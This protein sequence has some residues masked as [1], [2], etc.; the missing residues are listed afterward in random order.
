M[1]TSREDDIH[2]SLQ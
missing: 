2:Y 1:M